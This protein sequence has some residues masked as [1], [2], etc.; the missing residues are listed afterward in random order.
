MAGDGLLAEALAA[1]ED[2]NP[3]SLVAIVGPTASGKTALAVALAEALGGEVVSADSVQIYDRFDIGSGKP[4]PDEL[5]RARH[6]LVGTV[7]PREAFDAAR[8]AEAA[9]R[10]IADI[11]SRGKRPIL[12]GGTFLWV[13]ALIFGLAHAPA[14]SPEIR[15][16][17]RVESANE[18]QGALHARLRQVDPELAAR[19]H[20]NDLV[21]VSRGLEVFEL[22][23]R[24][25]S[26]WQGEHGFRS[27]RRPS[28]LFAIQ[29]SPETLT[30]RIERRVSEWLDAGGVAEVLGLLRD[31]YGEARAMRSVGYREVAD[32]VLGNLARDEL[33]RAIVRSTRVFARRQR[34]WLNHGDVRWLAP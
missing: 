20:P 21:R 26:S 14:A 22:T 23:G 17:H 24:P 32:H 6:H 34:T 27:A 4:S 25:L 33:P 13:K 10:A 28:I 3:A 19:L 16:R 7:D 1:I 11:V 2:A 31:G 30:E 9:E 18:G 8:Y 15:E 5:A 12:C 29:R